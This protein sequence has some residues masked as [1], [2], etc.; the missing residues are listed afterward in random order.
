MAGMRLGAPGS[1]REGASKLPTRGDL[2]WGTTVEKLFC[3]TI[4][5]A[6]WNWQL[7]APDDP[8]VRRMLLSVAGG[9]SAS[10]AHLPVIKCENLGC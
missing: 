1:R 8:A 2:A 4:V 6:E 10:D 7:C 3:A 9:Y 5:D